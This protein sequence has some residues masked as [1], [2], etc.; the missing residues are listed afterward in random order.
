MKKK[1]DFSLGTLN[2]ELQEQEIQIPD[3]YEASIEGGKIIFRKE[4]S[5]DEKIRKILVGFFKGY[6]EEDTIGSETFNG[7]PTDNI[8]AWLEK[9]S[10]CN[11]YSG[12]SFEYN[13]HTWGMCARDNGVEITLDGELKA[14]LSPKRSF[15]HP[16]HLQT[17]I[18]SIPPIQKPANETKIKSKFHEGDWIVFNGFTLL[19]EEVVQGYYRTVSINGIHNSYDWDIDNLARL[20]TIQDAKYG[21]VLTCYSSC[22]DENGKPLEQVGKLKRYIGKHGGCSNCFLAQI[23]IDWNGNIK[24]DMYMGS[25]DIFPATK[26]QRDYFFAETSKAGFKA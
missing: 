8:L 5:E 26:E 22:N 12:T 24:T 10:K 19:I 18:E 11:P 1:T 3:G 23:G 6:K 21:D 13:D 14:F 25:P 4:E 20:W 15:I 17:S 16:I 2:S 7:I 9:Q